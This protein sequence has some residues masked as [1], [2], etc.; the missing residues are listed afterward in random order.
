MAKSSNGTEFK[1]RHTAKL[2]KV[3]PLDGYI[4]PETVVTTLSGGGEIEGRKWPD[5]SFTFTV[6]DGAAVCVDFRI[7]SKPGDRP[8]RSQD[9]TFINVDELAVLSFMAHAGKEFQPGG[10]QFPVGN[11]QNAAKQ[12]RQK[13]ELSYSE[14]LAELK[15]VARIYCDPANRKTPAHNVHQLMAYKSRETSNRRIKAARDKGLIP[16]KKASNEEL[17]HQFE[18]LTK[19]EGEANG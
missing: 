3:V 11:D 18:L 8:I 5:M 17:D 10:F 7:I 9:L 6:R 19:E 16:P 14:P 4:V 12:V 15:Q 1:I 2:G 13:V